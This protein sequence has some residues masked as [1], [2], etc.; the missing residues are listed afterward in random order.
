M[1]H[2]QSCQEPVIH[3]QSSASFP[4]LDSGLVVPSCLPSDDPIAN[5]RV[6]VQNVQGRQNQGYAGSGAKGNAKSTRAN[7]NMGTNT[8]NQTKEKM[9]LAQAQEAGVVLD[10]EQLSFL[11]DNG[12]R[13][14]IGQDTQELTTTAIFQ[15]N[16][17][18]A[19]DSDYDSHGQTLCL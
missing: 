5:G 19:F 10:E 9:L 16:D 12:E 2:R 18:D 4:Q 11:A 14:A 3:Q 17:L 6:I 15:T 8:A 13:V 7:K 1:V